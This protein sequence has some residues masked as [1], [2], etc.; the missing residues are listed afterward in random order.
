M[1]HFPVTPQIRQELTAPRET[2]VRRGRGRRVDRGITLMEVLLVLAV[3]AAVAGMAA[4]ALQKTL[5]SHRLRS[6]ADDLRTEWAKARVQAMESGRTYTFRYQPAGNSFVVEPYSTDEDLVESSQLTVNG[7]P[8]AT[9]SSQ[10]PLAVDPLVNQ[11]VTKQLPEGITFLN[12]EAVLDTRGAL[13]TDEQLVAG[14]TDLQWSSPIFFYADGTTTTARISIGNQRSQCVYVAMR[15][16]TG[17]IEVSGV[18]IA[19]I[20]P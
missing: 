18:Q 5:D 4:P 1:T 9:S 17:V 15:G 13:L 12:A 11:A 3:L 20:L 19:E 14:T 16:L 10:D 6:A 8:L 7:L 2:T